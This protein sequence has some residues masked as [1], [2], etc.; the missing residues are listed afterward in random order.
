M[1]PS[2]HQRAILD[3]VLDTTD[4]LIIQAAAGSGKTT[5]L[6]LICETVPIHTRTL[7][8]CF[9]K[10]IAREFGNKLPR[11]VD[12]K[13]MHALGVQ[14][15]RSAVGDI[16][17][18][19]YKTANVIESYLSKVRNVHPKA[20][21]ALRNALDKLVSSV[22]AT[23]A[24]PRSHGALEGLCDAFNIDLDPKHFDRVSDILA[25]TRRDIR[26]LS[27]DDMIDHPI[28]HEYPFPKYDLVLVDE[29]QDLSPQQIEF[30]ARMAGTARIIAVGDRCQAIYA[31]R[32]ADATAMDRIQE[33]FQCKEFPLSVCYRCGE[34]I[35]KEAQGVVG[36]DVIQAA[37]GAHPGM[38]IHNTSDSYTDT[39]SKLDSGDLVL[40]RINRPLVSPCFELIRQGKKAIIRGRDIGSGLQAI[41]TRHRKK[42]KVN[43][44]DSLIDS[45]EAWS[46]R[47]MRKLKADGR[48]NQ[49]QTIEDQVQTIYAIAENV[50]TIDSLSLAIQN[51]FS[52]QDEGVIFSSIHK[53]KGL[54][55]NCVV[56][57]GPELVPHPMAKGEAAIAQEHNLDYVAK[58]R[59][60]HALIYQPL[61][62]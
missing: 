5:T 2:A 60:I 14:V 4:N 54:E 20:M 52:D 62:K 12:S 19:Q 24:D 34:S 44:L 27:Y 55:A 41:I 56:Y 53:A 15:C 30:V 31:F 47:R 23:N 16:K 10:S 38:V 39:V 50:D 36:E 8:V 3:A 18:D 21:Y 58:T 7:A 33:R 32:G 28:Y 49:A 51:T 45:I 61:E 11:H 37:P 35:V 48:E 22:L 43:D 25:L 9:N 57:L 1:E 59:A 26:T 29:A 46:V 42:A 6:R 13:T 40:S 17:I